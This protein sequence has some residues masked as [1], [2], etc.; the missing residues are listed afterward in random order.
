VKPGITC[1]W[2]VSGR[3]E[4]DFHEWMKLDLEYIDSWTFWG[5]IQIVLRTIPAVLFGRGAH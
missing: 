2:Q 5:D 3:S 1:T 4:V